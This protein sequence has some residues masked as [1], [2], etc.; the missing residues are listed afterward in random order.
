MSHKEIRR[1]LHDNEWWFVVEDVVCSLM[2]SGD[3]RQYIERMKQRDPELRK[4]WVQIV[5]TL[6]IE[7]TD[8]FQKMQC[9]NLEGVFRIIQSVPALRPEPYKQWL[10]KIGYEK[11]QEIF[12]PESVSRHRQAAANQRGDWA[13][14]SSNVSGLMTNLEYIFSVLGE[15]ATAEIAIMQG[16][17]G[18]DEKKIAEEKGIRI[19][20][21]ARKKLVEADRNI[22]ISENFLEEVDNLRRN[23]IKSC[24]NKESL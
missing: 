9:A 21:E 14:E 5:H 13:P 16:H 3:T 2:E 4:G 20:N 12:N 8:G 7:T 19:A 10:A 17:Q 24:P 11:I 6:P 23:S 22:S 1:T 18:S 15:A